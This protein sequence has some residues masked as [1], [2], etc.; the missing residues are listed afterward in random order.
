M[1]FDGAALGQELA[2]M[3]RDYFE[4]EVAPLEA[5]IAGLRDQ[6][7]ALERRPAETPPPRDGRDGLPGRDGKDGA[8]G[9]DGRDGLGFE[10]LD[11]TSDGAR[12][13]TLRFVRGDRT[14]EFTL[15][16]AAIADRGVWRDGQAY[17]KGDAV[18]FGG[19]LW[20][21]QQDGAVG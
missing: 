3:V 12:M 16:V 18:S 5:E 10:D 1:S 15:R 4:R 9:Q 2:T 14:R 19:S 21:C 6:V 13:I 7:R 17:Q 11:A 8:P 20:I